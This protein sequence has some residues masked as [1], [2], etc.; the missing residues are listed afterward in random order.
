MTLEKP[1]NPNYAATCVTLRDFV[2]LAGCDRIKGAI[3]FGSQVIVSKDAKAGDRGL[4][5]PV[6]TALSAEFLAANSLF[7]A[8]ASTVIK[9]GLLNADPAKSGFFEPHGRVKCV[10][11]RGHRSE[12]FFISLASLDF[13]GD[14][15]DAL[16]D[17]DT[18]DK[19]GSFEICRKHVTKRRQGLGFV[20]QAKT[21]KAQDRIVEGQ[22]R[23]HYDTEKLAKN[24]HWL[25][26][27]SIISVSDKFHG[28]SVVIANLL[29]TRRLSWLERL[30]GWLGAKIQ[31]T[32]YQIVVSSR[33]VVKSVGG[34]V[35]AGLSYY[36]SDVWSHWAK[37]IQDK[38]S[39][40][41]T[42]YGEIVGYTPTG[43]P[44]Q[45]GYSYGCVPLEKIDVTNLHKPSSRLL[46]YRV[47]YTGPDGVVF[48]LP[49]LQMRGWCAARGLEVVPE[50]FYGRAE[51]F[52]PKLQDESVDA[53]RE[54]FL[55]RTS[56]LYVHD[57]DC[58]HNPAGTPSEGIV[59]RCDLDN[60]TCWA[61]KQKNFRFLERESNL[62]DSEVPDL[63]E[64]EADG[65]ETVN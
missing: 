15:S 20:G 44:I 21:P 54:A 1:I 57:Q 48:E 5:F 63:E 51:H 9:A 49:W 17:G 14:F 30:A 56:E 12:G 23:F 24:L 43:S 6:E 27:D 42:V 53:W 25:S 64:L 13:I 58:P 40:G 3:I 47:T 61:L 28:T 46:V 2:E 10:K 35:K 8:K 45:Q 22:F 60:G 39:Q 16:S 32:E 37:Q 19:L 41:Y 26:P 65:L 18:F 34:E 33:K 4:F 31:A 11:F 59:V 55:G 62:M 52:C 36:D 29:A 7:N 38:I 50:L